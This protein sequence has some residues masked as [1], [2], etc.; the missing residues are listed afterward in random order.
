MAFLAT[1]LH[2]QVV[3]YRYRGDDLLA[4]YGMSPAIA[5]NTGTAST[6]L[7]EATG[8]NPGSLDKNPVALLLRHRSDETMQPRVQLAV[9]ATVASV[10]PQSPVRIDLE[11]ANGGPYMRMDF[12]GPSIRLE[13]RRG[14]SAKSIQFI[15]CHR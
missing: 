12:A 10:R 11:R 8:L 9:A 4:R 3:T 6:C 13:H 1:D 7:I 15:D 2:G 14:D 5:G